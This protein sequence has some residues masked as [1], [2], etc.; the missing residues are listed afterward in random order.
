MAINSK[1]KKNI[2]IGSRNWE[3]IISPLAKKEAWIK[4]TSSL[5]SKKHKDKANKNNPVFNTV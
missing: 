3:W 4:E 1:Y 2:K 5:P